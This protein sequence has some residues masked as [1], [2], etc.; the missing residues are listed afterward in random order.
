LLG[1][2]LI[3]RSHASIAPI[4]WTASLTSGP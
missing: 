3:G 1:Y 4:S 2:L